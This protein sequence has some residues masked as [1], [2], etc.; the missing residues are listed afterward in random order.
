MGAQPCLGKMG[1]LLVLPTPAVSSPCSG[2][3]RGRD[4]SLSSTGLS[5]G[6]R[7]LLEPSLP[8]LGNENKIPKPLQLAGTRLG[9]ASVASKA[10]V[11]QR[12]PAASSQQP[13]WGLVGD[14]A[15]QP[16]GFR[17]SGDHGGRRR[18]W[19]WG[20]GL[21]TAGSR[22]AQ[23]R[24]TAPGWR[25]G[26]HL[27]IRPCGSCRSPASQRWIQHRLP[28]LFRSQGLHFPGA[29]SHYQKM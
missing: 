27:L 25:G 18:V 16:L 29:E 20:Q 10:G 23:G 8:L 7:T 3:D 5:C 1:S 15:W 22:M 17:S 11:K 9:F 24:A 13:A 2:R 28:W 26:D 12:Q 4:P 14:G 21:S 6:P 19:G